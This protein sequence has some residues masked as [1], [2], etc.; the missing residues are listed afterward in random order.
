M[1]HFL[2]VLIHVGDSTITADIDI[3]AEV[4]VLARNLAAEL[5]LPAD[6]MYRLIPRS[7]LVI[8]QGSELD[9]VAMNRSISFGLKRLSFIIDE[10]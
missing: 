7:R 9:L 4:D 6:Q 5:R 1:S 2:Q 3:D 10:D 8:E